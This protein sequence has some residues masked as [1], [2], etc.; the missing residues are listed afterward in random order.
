MRDV[1]RETWFPTPSI[2]N[3][4]SIAL[5]DQCLGQAQV[6]R[7]SDVFQFLKLELTVSFDR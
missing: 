3:H 5:A 4:W 2:D 1:Q 7:Q 6:A